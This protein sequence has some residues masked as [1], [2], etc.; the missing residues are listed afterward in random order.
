MQMQQL[1]WKKTRVDS[2]PGLGFGKDGHSGQPLHRGPSCSL[3]LGERAR[4]SSGTTECPLSKTI[5]VPQAGQCAGGGQDS[6]VPVPW[7]G[8]QAARM[9]LPC[10]PGASVIPRSCPTYPPEPDRNGTRWL[11]GGAAQCLPTSDARLHCPAPSFKLPASF[12]FYLALGCAPASC[13]LR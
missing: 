4:K 11:S 3:R 8:S 2:R 1:P 10:P 6:E 5:G 12:G 13:R 7:R 9:T